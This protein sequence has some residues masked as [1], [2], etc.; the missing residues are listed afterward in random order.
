MTDVD[1]FPTAELIAV[2]QMALR[3]MRRR[4]PNYVL[5][6]RLT[7]VQAEKRL[8]RMEAIIARLRRDEKA[9]SLL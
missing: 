8:A 7:Q 3:S 4:Y 2:A 9:E 1:A 5:T 6:G